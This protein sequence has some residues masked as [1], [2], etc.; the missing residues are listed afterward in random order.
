MLALAWRQTQRSMFDL[1]PGIAAQPIATH[2]T[3]TARSTGTYTAPSVGC[4]AQFG[5]GG[6]CGQHC[7]AVPV[8]A[9]LA[10]EPAQR[11]AGGSGSLR[12]CSISTSECA[13]ASASADRVEGRACGMGRNGRS[14]RRKAAAQP[15]KAARRCCAPPTALHQTVIWHLCGTA[16]HCVCRRRRKQRLRLTQAA[17][18]AGVATSA[19][20]RPRPCVASRSPLFFL[21]G[22]RNLPQGA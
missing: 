15:Y 11:C 3:S 22:P 14:R 12:C 20:H 8:V 16:R 18:A 1:G 7:T 4:T 10:A 17:A 21:P 5:E 19:N 6:T 9:W 2:D 13:C